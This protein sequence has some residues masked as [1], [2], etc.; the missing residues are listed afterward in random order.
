LRIERTD[1]SDDVV[2]AAVLRQGDLDTR[3]GD[4]PGLEKYELVAM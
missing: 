1:R 3:P 2:V 4:L